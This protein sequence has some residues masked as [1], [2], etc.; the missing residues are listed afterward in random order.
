M[1]RLRG[2]LQKELWHH[3]FVLLLLAAFVGFAQAFLLLGSAVGPRT[4]TM[5]EAHAM[6]MRVFLPMLGLALGHRLVVREYQAH[7]QRFLESL[8]VYR[9]EILA[10]KFGLGLAV[11]GLAVTVSLASAAAIA[12]I[13]EPVTLRWL[14]L[15]F[16]RSQVFALT[17][18]SVFF[19]MGLLG[20]WRIP[21]YLAGALLLIFVDQGTELDV[22]R[23]G[24][25]GLVGGRLVLERLSTPWLELGVSLGISSV[26]IALS[27]A[28]TLLDEGSAAESLAKRMSRRE[29]VAVGV[30]L[31]LAL[32]VWDA[33]DPKH[34][35]LPFDFQHASVVRRPDANL[36]VL[37]LEPSNRGAA[38]ALAASLAQALVRAH[39]DLGHRS[40][41]APMH[42]AL[43]ETLGPHEYRPVDLDDPEDGVLLRVNF[44]DPAFDRARFV[45]FALERALEHASDG[46]AAFE[47]HAWVRS[48]TAGLV[49][50]STGEG[51][52]RAAYFYRRHRRP[53]YRALERYRRTEERFGDDVARALAVSA[54]SVFER[55]RGRA[56]WMEFASEVLRDD[57]P[58]GVFAALRER[59]RSV[60]DR[61][62]SATGGLS[63]FEAR[64]LEAVD[65]GSGVPEASAWVTHETEE[66]QLR[67]VLWGVRFA[68]PP[69]P[70]TLCAL[71]HA[72][73]GPFDERLEPAALLRQELPCAELGEAGR[74]LVGRYSE[75]DRVFVAVEMQSREIWVRLF[76][77]RR[78][79]R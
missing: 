55:A 3:A 51:S 58:P 38:D 31:A 57:P 17:A 13:K 71:V 30:V 36:D 48:G 47:P 79:L 63:A 23:F 16:V 10:T 65:R 9:W 2:L 61:F 40:P 73:L 33:V 11:L 59:R 76:A 25:F 29:R 34:D 7:T 44:T 70:G 39:R 26:A 24:P 4:I 20:R 41:R 15:I 19:L 45:A 1:R 43:R 68:A 56:A 37:F 22:S 62:A 53:S 21:V 18:F 78:E 75:H 27:A 52:L 67:S 46:R 54:A 14:S 28:L 12:F 69:E 50:G 64:W 35:K 5:F 60:R 77:E 42:V 6:F 66:G 74:R 72:P 49:A 32:I 8:P